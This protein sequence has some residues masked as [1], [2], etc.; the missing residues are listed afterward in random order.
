MPAKDAVDQAVAMKE[1]L[2]DKIERLG[3]SFPPNTL[4][5]LIDQLGGPA[6]VAEVGLD[7]ILH[8]PKCTV[9]VHGL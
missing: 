9:F 4:D 2:L 7:V 6:S 5:E 8:R 1:E 3:D